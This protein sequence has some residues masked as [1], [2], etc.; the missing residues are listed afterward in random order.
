[1]ALH[2]LGTTIIRSAGPLDRF[3]CTGI[4]LF[5]VM[6]FNVTCRVLQLYFTPRQCSAQTM[7]TLHSYLCLGQ[8]MFLKAT[9]VP[10]K[11]GLLSADL[12]F[13]YCVS[14]HHLLLS[15]WPLGPIL[16]HGPY[17]LPG[18]EHFSVNLLVVPWPWGCPPG[19]TNA[20][21]FEWKVPWKPPPLPCEL[22]EV[23]QDPR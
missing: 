17:E 16:T 12:F 4:S 14:T 21:M 9:Y 1:M 3:G 5:S 18:T 11:E 22:T 7:T 2:S 8:S 15:S 10:G 6:F 20:F 19:L 13:Q 23:L